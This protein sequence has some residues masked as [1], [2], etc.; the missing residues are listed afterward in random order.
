MVVVLLDL[1]DV[2]VVVPLPDV[3]GLAVPAVLDFVV[4]ATGFIG[5]TDFGFSSLAVGFAGD[6]LFGAGV[7]DFDDW[8]DVAWSFLLFDPFWPL[9]FFDIFLCLS[10]LMTAPT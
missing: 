6:S 4:F 5:I 3:L 1:D 9:F 10:F 8:V 2:V 7:L